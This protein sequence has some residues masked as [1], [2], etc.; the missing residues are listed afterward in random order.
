MKKQPNH[1]AHSITEIFIELYPL[2]NARTSWN[3]KPER[4]V[5]LKQRFTY[6]AA[7]IEILN[8]R[9]YRQSNFEEGN[10]KKR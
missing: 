2:R 4:E 1:Y 9:N 7:K 6:A 8:S 10:K 3:R 5:L